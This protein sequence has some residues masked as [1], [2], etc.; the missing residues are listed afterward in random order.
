MVQE[1]EVLGSRYGL[2]VIERSLDGFSLILRVSDRPLAE[3]LA[4]DEQVAPLLCTR[5]ERLCLSSRCWI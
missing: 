5:L 3:L 2:T 1:I 4:R